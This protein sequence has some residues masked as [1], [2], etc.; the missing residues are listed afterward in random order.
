VSD[1]G[2][3]VAPE[4]QQRIFT[5]F[6]QVDGAIDRRYGGTG[7]GLSISREL[8]VL[9]GGEL[10]LSSIPGKGSTFVCYLPEEFSAEVSRTPT[11]S[12]AGLTG[13]LK[14][15]DD[16]PVPRTGEPH[17]LLIEDDPIFASTFG[18]VIH[19][20]G[21]K[22]LVASNGQQ[23]LRLAKETKP[24]GIILDVKLPDMDGWAVMD[25][26]RQDPLTA[27]IPVHFV[28]ALDASERGIGMG[29]VGYL[30]KPTGPG[31]LIRVVEALAPKLTTRSSRVLVVEDD[32]IT[33]D[34]VINELTREG[35]EVRR[36]MNGQ[37]ALEALRDDDFGCII[38]DL[39]LPDMDG[40]QLLKKLQ[41]ESGAEMPSVVVYTARALSKAEAQA[42]EAYAEAVVLKDGSSA[43]RLLDEVRLFVRRFKAGLGTRRQTAALPVH[44]ADVQLG[45]KKIL[46]VDD[47]MR[48]VYALSATLLAKGAE[49]LVADTGQAALNTLEQRPDVEAVLMDIMMPEMDGYEAMRRIRKDP[50]FREL[51]IIALTAK[52]M[53]GDQAKCLEAGA[54]DY[55]PK[56]IDADRL[57]GMLHARLSGEASHGG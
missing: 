37:A 41:E 28:S 47:D 39:S 53:K 31:D 56:P 30:T 10:Q 36:V 49:V 21:L 3:G 8:A 15:P 35:L 7:L 19:S 34:S 57:L 54:T 43:E 50:R 4:N 51:P 2:L 24:M 23:G 45:G 38:L 33:G 26:L 25:Q 14:M 22:Y 52:A 1:T 55:L 13:P 44:P 16:H 9:L 11:P 32:V 17:L 18:E 27:T 40:L 5:A 6:E 42:L 48:T 20:Q 46:V 29:A 12:S